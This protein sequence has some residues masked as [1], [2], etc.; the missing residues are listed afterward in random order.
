[1]GCYNNQKKTGMFLAIIEF[2]L[3]ISTCSHAQ[4]SAGTAPVSWLD[5]KEL[6]KVEV[7]RLFVDPASQQP[8]VTLADAQKKRAFPIWIGLSEAQAIQSEL[9]GIEHFRPLTHDLLARILT[10][11]NGRVYRVII[12]HARDNVFY[13]TLVIEKDGTLIEIDAR[14]S[15]SIVMALKFKAPIF[16]ARSLFEK[17]SISMQEP[18]A[19]EEEYGLVLQELNSEIAKYLS[20]ESDRGV[21]IAGISKGSRAE[22]DGLKIGDIFVKVGDQRIENLKSIQDT[23]AKSE[24][25][26]EAKIFRNQQIL[27]LTLH[28]K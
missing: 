5:D 4:I 16:I 26:V 7:Y 21:M 19:A 8:V 2:W 10:K 24:T 15:D 1:M 27:I 14:P 12:T 3:M 13:A 23:L 17:M 22:K 6:I 20:F 18:L 11:I 25:S 28:L 9:E